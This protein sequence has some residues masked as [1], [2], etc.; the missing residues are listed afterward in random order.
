MADFERAIKTVLAHEGRF[1]DHKSD[2]GGATN[3]GISLR[4][5]LSTGDLDKDGWPDGDINYDGEINV[6]DIKFLS[7]DDAKDL[8]R[9]YFWDKLRLDRL[10]ADVIATKIFDIAVNTGNTPAIKIVQRA[11]RSAIGK[12]LIDDGIIGLQTISYINMCNTRFNEPLLAAIKSEAAGYYRA[13]RY[14]GSKDFLKGWLNRA[15]S[16]PIL[17]H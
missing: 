7:I 14:K 15:Y 9:M 3:Y 6:E 5:L 1:V 12:N 13:I 16:D 11:V 2:P 10:H 17:D 4:F 8:Y